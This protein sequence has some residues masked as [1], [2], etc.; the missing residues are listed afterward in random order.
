M[1]FIKCKEKKHNLKETH[2][3]SLEI[4]DLLG[5]RVFKQ[6]TIQIQQDYFLLDLSDEVAGVYWVRIEIDDLFLLKRLVIQ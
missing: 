1:I 3:V 2:S 6:P 4:F 5:R